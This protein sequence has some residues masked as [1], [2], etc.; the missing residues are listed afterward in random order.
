MFR[1]AKKIQIKYL[2]TKF[3]SILKQSYVMIKLVSFQR[4]KGGNT[5]KSVSAIQ[6]INRIK[7]KYYITIS[8]DAEK[9]FDKIQYPFMI[10][11]LKK[12]GIEGIYLN[13]FKVIYNEPIA[14]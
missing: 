13:I 11:A 2:Q 8:I 12:L 5:C 7:D 4:C 6:H 3:H 10:K 1:D 9:A 14:N